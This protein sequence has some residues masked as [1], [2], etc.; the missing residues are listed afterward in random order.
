MLS[1]DEHTGLI[2][3]LGGMVILVLVGVF[4]SL[5]LDQRFELSKGNHAL[6]QVV[7]DDEITLTALKSDVEKAAERLRNR[8][9][10]YRLNQEISLRS[11]RIKSLKGEHLALTASIEKVEQDMARH[12]RNLWRAAVGEKIPH[13]KVWGGREYHDVTI[14]QVTEAG[15]EI[16]HQNGLAR[17]AFPDLDETWH[18]RFRWQESE[19]RSLLERENLS[20]SSP[21]GSGKPAAAQQGP[22]PGNVGF[23]RARVVMWRGR[24]VALADEYA[25]A[26]AQQQRNRSVPKSLETW[27]RKAASISG[28][29][30]VANRELLKAEERLRA[31]SPDDELFQNAP[32]DR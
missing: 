13:L 3:F 16:Q 1:F 21:N 25:N 14:R 8:D 18:Q 17:I 31:V 32:S 22:L 6:R 30:A 28:K 24:T 5:L 29:L 20:F 19:R 12:R 7:R 27:S 4:F 2:S 9:I 11:E 10:A 23:L 26:T 15:L